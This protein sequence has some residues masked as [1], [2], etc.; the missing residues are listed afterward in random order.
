MRLPSTSFPL[1]GS[2]PWIPCFNGF[3]LPAM[4]STPS[5]YWVGEL[6]G[7][8][9][10]GSANQPRAST[11]LARESQVPFNLPRNSERKNLLKLRILWKG[12][13]GDQSPAIWSLVAWWP[14][15]SVGGL[16]SPLATQLSLAGCEQ[17]G[18]TLPS[19]ALP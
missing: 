17:F 8:F 15:R 1:L 10:R 13:R 3:L 7:H 19:P 12:A 11:F 4:S 9:C 18:E 5:R 6:W 14:W 2:S 16:R